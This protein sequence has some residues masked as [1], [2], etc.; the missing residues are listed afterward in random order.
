MKLASQNEVYKSDQENLECEESMKAKLVAL[1][2]GLKLVVKGSNTRKF[3][4][5]QEFQGGTAASAAVSHLE[6]T[7]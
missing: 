5:F 2:L 1:I 7:T 3:L 6:D 4:S